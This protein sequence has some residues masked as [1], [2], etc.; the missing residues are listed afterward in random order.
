MKPI[1]LFLLTTIA[2]FPL[3][4]RAEEQPATLMTTR[5]KL[6]V[7]QNFE[8]PLPPFDGKSNGFASGFQAWRYNSAARGGHWEVKDG[9]FTGAE[10]PAAQ[11]PATASYGFDF[12]DVVIQCEVRM[13]AVPLDG[14]KF[15]SLSVRTTDAKDYVCS[16]ILNEGGFRIQKDDNDHGGP[17]KSVPLG[18]IKTPLNLD[19]WHKVLFEIEGDEMVVTV[20]GRSLT[21]THPLIA[22]DKHSVM[23]VCGVEGS[24]RNLKVWEALPNPEWAKNKAKIPPAE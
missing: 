7:E 14:R 1:H 2:F 22:S 21:G 20:D 24:V 17:D 15:R 19:E 18:A 9:T 5:G 3:A 12:K 4:T 13:N 23:F 11:H 8:K 10:N 16:V 6:L